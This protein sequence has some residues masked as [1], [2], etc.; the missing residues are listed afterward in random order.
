MKY[1]LFSSRVILHRDTDCRSQCFPISVTWLGR[2]KT[3]Q[4][5]KPRPLCRIGNREQIFRHSSE[6]LDA[7]LSFPPTSPAAAARILVLS[8]VARFA[9]QIPGA[10]ACVRV[11][12]SVTSVNVGAFDIKECRVRRAVC[13]YRRLST[14]PSH[15]HVSPSPPRPAASR[16]VAI[17]EPVRLH[18]GIL[19]ER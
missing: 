10:N 8:S 4:C 17:K 14:R 19:R 18:S 2:I 1:C 11:G 7:F 13:R 16:H 9:I 6:Y 12:I 15:P 3:R 5:A